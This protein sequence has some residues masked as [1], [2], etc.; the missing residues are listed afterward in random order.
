MHD[1]IAGSIG[2]DGEDHAAARRAA[3]CRA[4][5]KDVFDYEN[6]RLKVAHVIEEETVKIP[7]RVLFEAGTAVRTIKLPSG[8]E[9]LAGRAAL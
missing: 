8:A 2:V 5:T 7:P 9:T 4:Q 6:P 1:G 3:G